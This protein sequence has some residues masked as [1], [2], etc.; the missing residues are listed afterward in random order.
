[1]SLGL[2]LDIAWVL[3]PPVILIYLVVETYRDHKARKVR[4]EKEEEEFENSLMA[5]YAPTEYAEKEGDDE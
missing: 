3:L 4:E 5:T 1:M 2:L